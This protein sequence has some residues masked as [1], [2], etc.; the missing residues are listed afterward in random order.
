[1]IEITTDSGKLQS[2]EMKLF[3]L[4]G[5]K[6][7]PLLAG[8][9]KRA[10]IHAKKIGSK[11]VR[12]IY[13]IDSG[14]V[15]SAIGGIRTIGMGAEL[16]IAGPRKSVGHYKAR[17]NKRGVY[18]SIKK[19]SGDTLARSFAWS[20]TFFQREGKSRTPIKRLFGPAVPQLF[21]NPAVHQ[22][23]ET[24]ALKKYEERVAHELSRVIGG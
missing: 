1:M 18:V 20:N 24:A 6:I 8:A 14:S 11:R 23:L 10:A 7:T 16:R 22:E 15:K 13:T 3:M 21:D 12:S 4:Q 2:L 17:Q 5:E 9:A 19:G